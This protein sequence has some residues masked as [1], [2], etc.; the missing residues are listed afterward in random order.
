[1]CHNS[2]VGRKKPSPGCEQFKQSLKG[3][4]DMEQLGDELK[5]ML[6]A[7]MGAVAAGLEM[8]QEAIENLAQ[9]GEPLYQQAKSAVADA[10]DKVKQAVNE[11]FSAMNTK[12]QVQELIDTLRGMSKEDWDQVRSALDEFEA[13]AAEAEQAAREAAQ[14]AEEIMRGEAPEAE[15]TAE[16]A[17]NA[18]EE[19]N[20]EQN[21]APE[22]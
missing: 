4:N 2:S 11:G 16:E 14:A 10:A 6:K 18:S 7:G 12:P 5:K 3:V 19:Q 15:T 13:Q 20:E 1:M 8:G 21:Q 22:E 9:K 17:E